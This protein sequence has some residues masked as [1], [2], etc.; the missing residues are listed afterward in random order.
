MSTTP[1]AGTEDVSGH[2]VRPRQG[3]PLRGGLSA[4]DG[5]AVTT[6]TVRA[7]VRLLA[8]A[9]ALLVVDVVAPGG[10]GRPTGVVRAV[11]DS[12]R[13]PGVELVRGDL[14]DG[15]ALLTVVLPRGEHV[16]RISYDGDGEHAASSAP[17]RTMRVVAHPTVVTVASESGP[18]EAPVVLL[19]ARVRSDDTAPVPSG[20]VVFLDGGQELGS[21]AVGP[22]GAAVL[23][24]PRLETGVHRIVAAYSGDDAHAAAR[25]AAMPH[26]VHVRRVRTSVEVVAGAVVAEGVPVTV[27]VVPAEGPHARATGEVLVRC[28]DAELV[29]DLV[30]GVGS[31]TLP[32]RPGA[33][34]SA[35][36]VASLTASYGG[37]AEHAAS[38]TA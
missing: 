2:L 28:A 19:T 8:G 27:R 1:E 32:V 25:S 21:A 5:R 23:A 37:D 29:I 13:E 24:A 14:E 26:A 38:A 34:G 17:P 33:V 36:L 10:A 3:T 15:R 4:R 22:D 16:L 7:P 30:D 20:T 31:G 18:P 6:T 35:S 11:L 9:G 12:G